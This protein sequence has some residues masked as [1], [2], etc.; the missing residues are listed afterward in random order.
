MDTLVGKKLIN[1]T[2]STQNGFLMADSEGIIFSSKNEVGE[3][4]I[5]RYLVFRKDGKRFIYLIVFLLIIIFVSII[6]S[7]T[8][9]NLT[10]VERSFLHFFNPILYTNEISNDSL[11]I[12]FLAVFAIL[13]IILRL[14][15]LLAIVF[16][17]SNRKILFTS[18]NITYI[19]VVVNIILTLMVFI[20]FIF[21]VSGHQ[22]KIFK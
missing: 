15:E 13:T 8:L 9:I 1:Y 2:Y 12:N 17:L 21:H 19:W 10:K 16:Y 22:M 11:N 6:Q 5:K 4:E 7:S 3:E 14:L 18:L 20:G